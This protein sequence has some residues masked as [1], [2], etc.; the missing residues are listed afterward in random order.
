MTASLNRRQFLAAGTL[1]LAALGL[2]ACTPRQ[3]SAF[4]APTAEAVDAAEAR[5]LTTGATIERALTAEPVTLDLAGQT[6]KTW[7][8]RGASAAEPIRGNVGDLLRVTLSNDLPDPTTV[9][10]H[11]L[12]LRTDMDGVPGLTQPP[13]DAGDTFTYEFA[14]PH[15]G[16]YWFH[17]HV[18]T[19]L[20]R[21][22]YA[23]LIIDDPRERGDYDREWVIVLDDWLDG[24]NATPDGKGICGDVAPDVEEVAKAM[25]PVPGGVGSLTTTIIMQNVLKAI[26]LQGLGK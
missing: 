4:L 12:A 17:P 20:D 21:G 26:S 22:L 14:L 2:A 24:I 7:G 9:H 5:R 3:S 8:Y 11:G 15:A 6:V 19:Q 10:W 16:T 18:G 25:T 1:T 23:P 13:I